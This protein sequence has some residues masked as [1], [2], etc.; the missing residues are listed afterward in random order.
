MKQ[1]ETNLHNPFLLK[2]IERAVERIFKALEKGA[3]TRDEAR[4]EL[5]AYSTKTDTF[6]KLA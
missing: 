5:K 3:I 4:A 2:D 6:A 1:A